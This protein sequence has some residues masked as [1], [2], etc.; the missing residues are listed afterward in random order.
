ML[1]QHRDRISLIVTTTTTTN[2]NQQPQQQPTTN[3]HNNNQQPQQPTTT[4]TT[5]TNN[6]N[7]QKQPTATNNHNNNQQPTTTTTTNNHNN[8]QPQQPQQPTTTN[9]NQQQ[10]TTTNNHNNNQQPTTTTTTNNHNNQQPQQ[11]QQPTTTTTKN[12]HYH[13]HH[14][15]YAAQGFLPTTVGRP[16]CLCLERLA[17]SMAGG[18]VCGEGAARHRRERRLRQWVRH[19]GA[20]GANGPGRVQAPLLTRMARAG[21]VEEQETNVGL[22]AQMPPPPG[23]R[24]AAL[25]EPVPQLGLE[26][27]ACP[28][29]SGVP[30]LSPPAL[31]D[32]VGDA[33]DS[34]TLRFASSLPLL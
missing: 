14:Q 15:S 33:V 12:N 6:H 29:S 10:P 17:M 30:S 26:H 19:E 11:P 8:Q 24:P 1:C 21:Q 20:V 31:A 5:T 4:T 28:C 9:N 13:H 34:A 32:A 3:N 27:A 18:D 22:R 23:T 2:S 25:R 16:L 7:N